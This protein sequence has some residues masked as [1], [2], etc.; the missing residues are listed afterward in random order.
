MSVP[1]F[2]LSVIGAVVFF[3]ADDNPVLPISVPKPSRVSSQIA[4]F[5]F[6]GRRTQN[7][8]PC[9][10]SGPIRGLLRCA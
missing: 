7:P 5:A 9:R 8:V 3:G 6:H 1:F 4:T 10:D 2:V